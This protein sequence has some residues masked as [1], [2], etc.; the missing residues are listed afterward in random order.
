MPG[1]V[2]AGVL[3]MTLWKDHIYLDVLGWDFHLEG[4]TLAVKFSHEAEVLF[5]ISQDSTDPVT[6]HYKRK[7]TK[8]GQP[9][10]VDKS[11]PPNGDC[12]FVMVL[13]EKYP[14]KLT[15]GGHDL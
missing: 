15:I 14:R 13:N 5:V 1:T 3:I 4:D 11:V 6:I 12:R 10:A 8:A 2:H 7:R 9:K